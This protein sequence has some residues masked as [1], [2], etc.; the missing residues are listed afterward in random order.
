MAEQTVVLKTRSGHPLFVSKP[1]LTNNSRVFSYLI[2]ELK[3]EELEMDAFSAES[4]SL[5]LN[6]LD[7]KNLDSVE[8]SIFK[9]VHK[10]AVVFEVEWLRDGCR[11][12]LRSK[13]KTV[14]KDADK[15]FLFDECWY[16]L[17]K[18]EEKGTMDAL[19][20]CLAPKDNTSFIS[21]Y[22]WD[23][24]QLETEQIDLMLKLGGSNTE[25][26][27]RTI[28]HNLVGEKELS[29]N[30]KHLLQKINLPL[31]FE[32]NEGIYLEVFE[33]VSTLQDISRADMRLTYQLTL[34]TTRALSARREKR[35]R[36]TS[37]V[38]D[39]NKHTD[40]L[41]SC[42]T[43]ADVIDAINED[44]VTSMFVVVELLIYI[45]YVN[46][47]NSEATE[48]FLAT[49][50]D[51]SAHKTIQKITQ[52]YLDVIIAAL[53]Y[54]N[55][56]QTDQLLSLL[57][58]IKNND[59]LST[60]LENVLIKSEEQVTVTEESGCKLRLFTYRH[61]WTSTCKQPSTCGFILKLSMTDNNTTIELC[62]DSA[63]YADT[64]IHFHEVISAEEMYLYT[65][66]VGDTGEGDKV[67]VAGRCLWWEDWLPGVADWRVKQMYVVYSV[68]DYLVA[69][70]EYSAR[71]NG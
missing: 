15:L 35:G 67:T 37:A 7:D 26:F 8:N 50:G 60:Y 25:L 11:T 10:L 47:P 56:A 68:R 46:T 1:R 59:N 45:F 23:I 16:I 38:Y 36:R 3:Y 9:E 48:M 6:I 5:F 22:M 58:E 43:L 49:L 69:K 42:K 39:M 66:R 4:V 62:R 61:P 44:H 31:C 13:M 54:S 29:V 52:Q 17:K 20:S 32:Q 28:L 18:W 57:Y 12:L 64:R 70:N 34:W 41:N 51:L 55:L 40:L 2:D 19:I 63:D 14:K 24:D 33:A 30:I 53:N 21:D 71:Q 65:V 27:L